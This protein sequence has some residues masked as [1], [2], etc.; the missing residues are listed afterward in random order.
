MGDV[1]AGV[2]D[3]FRL[4]ENRGAKHSDTTGIIR[5]VTVIECFE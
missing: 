3:T 5:V 2:F 4:S 1:S